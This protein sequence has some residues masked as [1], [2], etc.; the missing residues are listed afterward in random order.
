MKQLM[1]TVVMK[2]Y[3]TVLAFLTGTIYVLA[4]NS[5]SSSSTSTTTSQTQSF[6]MQ[7]WM[8]IAGGALFI[9]VL[10]ALL[11]GGKNKDSVTV[12]KTTTVENSDV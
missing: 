7:P 5:G 6:V 1:K 11:R 12:S 3:L 9:I 2:I 8:W 4:Q 10:V